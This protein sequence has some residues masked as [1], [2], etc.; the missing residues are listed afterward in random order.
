VLGDFVTAF[1]A[2]VIA[3]VIWRVANLGGQHSSWK[4]AGSC[5]RRTPSCSTASGATCG[6]MKEVALTLT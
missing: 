1:G 3:L 2:T 4:A 6:M 5:R